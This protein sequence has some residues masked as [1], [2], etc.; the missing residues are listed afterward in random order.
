MFA[1]LANLAFLV[2]SPETCRK[3]GFLTFCFRH[4]LR[5]SATFLTHCRHILSLQLNRV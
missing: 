2:N 3:H 4:I 5:L 1:A